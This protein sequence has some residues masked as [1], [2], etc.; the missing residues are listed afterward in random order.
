MSTPIP[1][2]V[3]TLAEAAKFLRVSAYKVRALADDGKIPGRKIGDE[4][5]FLQS[6]LV[7]WLRGRPTSKELF[8]RQAGFFKDDDTLPQM[9]EDIYKAR[10]RPMVQED[11]VDAHPRYGH[12]Q[13]SS[14][15]RS[16]DCS[17][18]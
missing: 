12:R 8:L 5:R 9:L 11:R 15:G 7:E 3:M 2:K 6:T 18:S 10:G 16:C 1:E 17:A 13:S 4:W 14:R